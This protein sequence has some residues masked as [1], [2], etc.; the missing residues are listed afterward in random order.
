MRQISCA[1]LPDG[2]GCSSVREP[3]AGAMVSKASDESFLWLVS[4]S[5]AGYPIGVLF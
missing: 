3:G 4:T 5:K 1:K 2:C